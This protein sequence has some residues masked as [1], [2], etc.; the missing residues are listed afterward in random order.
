MGVLWF[1]Y[2]YAVKEALGNKCRLK[3]CILCVLHV[4]A[5]IILSSTKYS[6]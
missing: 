1:L 3:R 6:T 4:Y 2:V 5:C